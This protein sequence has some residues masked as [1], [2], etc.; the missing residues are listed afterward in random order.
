MRRSFV[1]DPGSRRVRFAHYFTILYGVVG[2]FLAVNL[3][4]AS[5][6]AVAE[7][8]NS[9]VGIVAYYPKD[10]LLETR[11]AVLRVTDFAR[12]GFKTVIQIDVEPFAPRMS[13]RNVIDALT[14]ERQGTLPY[15]RNLTTFETTLRTQDSAVVS[16][17]TF[18]YAPND[19][20]LQT[21]T[22]VVVGRDVLIIR[23]NQAILVTFQADARTYEND[24]AVFDRFLD[25][26]EY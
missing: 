3:R 22:A 4:D 18:V 12:S 19:P 8:R 1:L 24:L 9:E 20:F 15:Y 6:Y 14:L 10:W 11:S 7:F 17:Y 5:L 16:E 21:I 25:A 23:R 26:L 13:A 2:L